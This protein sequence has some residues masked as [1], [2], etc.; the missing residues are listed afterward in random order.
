[1]NYNNAYKL[2]NDLELEIWKSARERIRHN[3]RR[4]QFLI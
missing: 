2:D 3:S 4:K 1:M